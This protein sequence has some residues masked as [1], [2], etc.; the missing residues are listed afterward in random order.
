M[1]INRSTAK[2]IEQRNLNKWNYGHLLLVSI[3]NFT[4]VL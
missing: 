4:Q 1:E 2:Y 3:C